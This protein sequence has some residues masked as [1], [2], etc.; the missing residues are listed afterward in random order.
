MAWHLVDAN[1]FSKPKLTIWHLEHGE[2]STVEII[3]NPIIL[4][5]E[6]V[7]ENCV[8]ISGLGISRVYWIFYLYGIIPIIIPNQNYS[9]FG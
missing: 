5:E 7:F 9:H 8:Y 2:Q 4:I 6:F 3:S 1:P